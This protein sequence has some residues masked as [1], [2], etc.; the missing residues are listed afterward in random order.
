MIL[1]RNTK[2][3]GWSKYNNFD[4]TVCGKHVWNWSDC[5]FLGNL[6]SNLSFYGGCVNRG[7]HTFGGFLTTSDWGRVFCEI[8]L[9]FLKEFGNENS[10]GFVFFPK[11][12]GKCFKSPESIFFFPQMICLIQP[13]PFQPMWF[14]AVFSPKTLARARGYCPFMGPHWMLFTLHLWKD[15][16]SPHLQT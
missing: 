2:K 6:A 9:V 4:G 15:T 16:H 12:Q 3:C 13:G 10:V 8:F 1:V 11:M 7:I 5:K 14:A